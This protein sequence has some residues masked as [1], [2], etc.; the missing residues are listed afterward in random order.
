MTSNEG[1]GNGRERSRWDLDL[2]SSF[3][4]LLH[5][6]SPLTLNRYT[7]LDPTPLFIHIPITKSLYV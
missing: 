5:S 2:F 3:T 6:I 7:Y 4:C 1:K